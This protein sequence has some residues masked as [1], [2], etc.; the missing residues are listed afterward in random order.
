MPKNPLVV[1]PLEEIG[2]YGGTIRRGLTGDI[3]QWP[4]IS[5]SMSENLLAF[6]RPMGENIEPNLAESCTFSD[7][8]RTA[9]VKIRRETRWSDGYPFTV[10]DI[11]FYYND[12]LFNEDARSSDIPTPPPEWLVDSKPIQLSK[13]DSFTL[14]ITSPKPMGRLRHTLASAGDF[15]APKHYWK[16]YHPQ[17]T[18]GADFGDFR[19]RTTRAKML[20]TPG[21][22]R[23]TAWVPT[24]WIRGQRLVYTRNPYYW[25][26][27]T[28]GNQLP[29]ADR[30]VFD[31]IGDSQVILL[32]FI[33]GEIDLFGRYSDISMFH[34]LKLEEKKGKFKIL[35]SGPNSGPAFYLNWDV[36][37]PQLREAFRDKRVRMALSHAINR[38]EVN[39]ILYKGFLEPSGYS[40]LPGNP[41]FSEKA[42][43][44]YS[45]YEPEK[46]K[47]LLEQAG[48]H[49]TDGDGIRELKDGRPFTVVIDASGR[50]AISDIG[51]LITDHWADI[52][53]KVHIYVALR[54]IIWPR[55]FNGEFQIHQWGLEG[56]GDPLNR[57][58]DWAITSPNTPFWHRN[59]Y[60][61][62]QPWFR[63]ATDLMHKAMSAVDTTLVRTYMERALELHSENV[64]VITVGSIYRVWGKSTRLGNVPNDISFLSVHGAWGKPIF[65]EQIF[66]RTEKN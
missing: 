51:E 30:L 13:V 36:K 22:P 6:S 64:P 4:G 40:F 14:K 16:K 29:Y 27:D 3:V 8:G 26:I 57:L 34:T 59:A 45:S 33:N 2:Q 17:Y 9:I 32:K 18:P 60:T 10:D 28:A 23:L 21:V 46:S 56:P 43:R 53:I 50:T 39:Q 62:T 55:R 19:Q 65:H 44:R 48:Y 7:S 52:G 1:V 20:M 11:L 61:E 5:K 37:D 12:M 31:I 25:K 15:A 66:I 24:E 35:I 49:D 63:E 58:D 41:Y 47:Q 54:D 38:D 42:Y